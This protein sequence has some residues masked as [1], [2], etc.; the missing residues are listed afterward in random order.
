M[1]QSL[2]D[3]EVY[4]DIEHQINRVVGLISVLSDR[5]KAAETQ[6]RPMEVSLQ[7]VH[8]LGPLPGPRVRSQPSLTS[9]H[10]M[11]ASV[12]RKVAQRM[13]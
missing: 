3:E 12:R 9:G 6:K 1:E 5:V 10:H 8:P 2:T 11:S 4:G 7:S 13:K